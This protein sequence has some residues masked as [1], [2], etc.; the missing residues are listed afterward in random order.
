MYFLLFDIAFGV[1]LL[2]KFKGFFRM[3][4]IS[5]VGIALTLSLF[6][7][8]AFAE[9]VWLPVATTTQGKYRLFMD[10]QT[11]QR[12][13]DVVNARFR[14]VYDKKQIFPFV[15]K[16]YDSLERQYYLECAQRLIV[17][18]GKYFLGNTQT[19]SVSGTGGGLLGAAGPQAAIPNTMEDE[20][21]NQACDYKP[22][23]Q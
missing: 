11:F 23:K 10:T 5:W 22:G 2:N 4:L 8:Q 14:Y 18:N 6:A 15:N 19:Y 13:G 12:E 3:K 17:A 21:I 9:D 1:T 16:P 20:A 7:H